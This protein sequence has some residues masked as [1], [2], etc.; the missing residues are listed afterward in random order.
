MALPSIRSLRAP[1]LVLLVAASSVATVPRAALAQGSS[2]KA[3]AESLFEEARKLMAEKKYPLACDKFAASQKLDPAPGTLLNLADCSDKAGRSASAWVEFLEAAALAKAAGDPKREKAA[4]KRAETLEPK[5]VRLSITVPPEVASLEGLEVRRDGVLVDRAQWAS[6]VPVDPGSHLVE[7]VAKGYR[8]WK[9]QVDASAA[10]TT[11]PVA[12]GKLEREPA[13]PPVVVASAPPPPPPPPP[14]TASAA[15]PPPL[16]PPPPPLEPASS[17]R[18][19]ALVAGGV[20]IVGLG[21]GTYLALDAKSKSKD[22]ET[23]CLSGKTVCDATAASESKDAKSE[24]NLATIPFALGL[25]GVGA[26]ITLWVTAPSSSE[27]SAKRIW[28][29][30]TAAPDRAGVTVGGRF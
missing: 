5:L 19:W 25:V 18:T 26:A 20:G 27:Q 13:P 10:G 9:T 21:I 3:A 14:A 11:V 15:P 22:A 30:P 2:E 6:A 1:A 16:V 12:I 23:H 29:T 4:R 28:M 24:A 8:Q 7:A 17:Q